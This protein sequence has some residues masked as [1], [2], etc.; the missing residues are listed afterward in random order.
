DGPG[1][2][3]TCQRKWGTADNP[4]A[5]D[6]LHT[7]LMFVYARWN[8]LNPTDVCVM[9]LVCITMLRGYF[10]CCSCGCCYCR[11]CSCDCSCGFCCRW[12]LLLL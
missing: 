3:P 5:V 6:A 1:M 8:L 7:V 12:L 11:C 9:M 2:Q 4:F 10:C